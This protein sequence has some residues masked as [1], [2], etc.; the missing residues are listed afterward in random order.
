M[1]Y[2]VFFD[3]KSTGG[4]IKREIRQIKVENFT[5]DQ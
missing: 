3:I 1:V 5:I 2:K 4:A